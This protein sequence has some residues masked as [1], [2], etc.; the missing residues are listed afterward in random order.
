MAGTRG[1]PKPFYKGVENYTSI[2]EK[3]CIFSKIRG[4]VIW[5]IFPPGISTPSH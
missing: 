2:N 5:K 4:F 3:T 1:T